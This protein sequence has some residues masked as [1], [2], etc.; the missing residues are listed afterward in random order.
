MSV[1]LNIYK[2]KTILNKILTFLTNL[3]PKI[4]VLVSLFGSLCIL[5]NCPRYL[6][7]EKIL[8]HKA[9]KGN[10]NAKLHKL[11]KEARNELQ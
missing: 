8:P 5:A 9:K 2:S 6:E 11:G 3:K 7:K 10:Y 4:R 1:K